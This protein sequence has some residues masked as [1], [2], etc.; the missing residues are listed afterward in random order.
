MSDYFGINVLSPIYVNN[1]VS[2]VIIADYNLEDVVFLDNIKSLIGSEITI[3]EKDLRINTTII[4]DGKRLIGTKLDSK[5]ANTVVNNKENY[6]GKA[7]ILGIPYIT[8]YKPIL[9]Y[10]GNVN[11]ILFTG[12]DYTFVENSILKA[13]SLITII[14]ILSITASIF[15]LINY[16]K[17][18]LK[19]PLD[20]VVAAATSIETG[21]IDENIINQLN[22][23]TTNDEI[24]SLARSMEGAVKSVTLLTNHINEY[25]TA[26]IS[27]DLT[28]TADSSAHRGIYLSIITIVDNLFSELRNILFEISQAAEQ[29]DAGSEHVSSAAQMLAQ[30]ATEQA[31]S[32]EEMAATIS[33]VSEQTKSNTL[34]SH[35]ASNL[36]QEAENEVLKSSQYMNNMMNSMEEISST[37]K[38]IEKIIKAIDDIAFQTNILA[39]NAAVE[40]ARAGV[41]GKGFAVVADEVRNLAS[42]SADAA[43][44]TTKLIE[45]SAAAVQKGYQFARETEIS[46]NN[47]VDKTNKT[48]LLINEIAVASQKQSDN[49][50][51]ISIGIDQISSVVQANS[52]TAEEIAASSE[53][54]TGQSQSLKA[55][56]DK[57]KL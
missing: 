19:G 41:A 48:N 8:V 42:K 44:S 3:F 46:L 53:E 38:E 5:I 2:G 26:V 11:G 17:K 24:G 52:A 14:S 45:S 12:S 20:K 10:D 18:R 40:A 39:L 34:T 27:N 30:G 28:Y 55:M 32:T 29:I 4:Q 37:S 33:D 25:K 35:E 36:S 54:L 47:V 31:S 15:I 43:K 1:V 22:D 7:D 56:V 51:Q 50:Y 16:F 49:I 57:Y 23:I 13:I 21:E 6:I 9:S